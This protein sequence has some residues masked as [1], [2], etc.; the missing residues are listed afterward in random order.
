M[1][2]QPWDIF[3]ACRIGNLQ[4]VTELIA[5]QA[6][7]VNL[8]D[9]KGF[10][11]LIL[12][13]YNNQP[14]IVDYLLANGAD[15]DAVDAAGNTALMGVCFKGYNEMATKLIEAG[16]SLNKQNMQGATALTFATSF[17]HLQIVE[18][19]L[20]SG[21][22]AALPD[23]RGKIPLDHARVQENWEMFDLIND[24]RKTAQ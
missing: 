21:A 3:D 9:D 1:R 24:Y 8:K 20:R 17:N 10:T 2:L 11:P 19:L 7:I 18:L 5:L 12:A 16:A 22:N 14:A 6:D 13:V 23:L 4:Q 15:T